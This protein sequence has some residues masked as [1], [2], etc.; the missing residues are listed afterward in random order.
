MNK[1]VENVLMNCEDFS[2]FCTTFF[3]NGMFYYCSLLFRQ[4]IFCRHGTIAVFLVRPPRRAHRRRT[5]KGRAGATFGALRATVGG[6][7]FLWVLVAGCGSQAE[8][9]CRACGPPSSTRKCG[10]LGRWGFRQQREFAASDR[11]AGSARASVSR[12]PL[13][14]GA[15]VEMRASGVR[16]FAPRSILGDG[17]G[18]RRRHG[19]VPVV[20]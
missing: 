3:S 8:A 14:D 1:I 13:P 15:T 2:Y 17:A 19:F 12:R 10:A 11:M 5:A 6:W 16:R 18:G 20:L 9:G 4:S 7:R